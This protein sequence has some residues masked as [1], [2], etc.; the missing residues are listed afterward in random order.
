MV[1]TLIIFVLGFIAA[2]IGSLIGLGG[3]VFVVPGLLLLRDHL[4]SYI[5]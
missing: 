5:M 3:G 4:V 1:L 2:V